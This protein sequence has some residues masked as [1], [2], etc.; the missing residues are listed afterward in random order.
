MYGITPKAKIEACEND[1]PENMFNKPTKPKN[2]HKKNKQQKN[3]PSRTTYEPTRYIK[4]NKSVFV[5]RTLKSSIFQMLDNVS[6]NFFIVV[7]NFTI[8]PPAATIA[9][10]AEA[11][12]ACAFTSSLAFSSPRPSIFTRSLRETKP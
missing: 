9:F 5:K 12:K 4:R 8:V 2:P 11:E 10:C 3:T 7:Y 1:P 6:K